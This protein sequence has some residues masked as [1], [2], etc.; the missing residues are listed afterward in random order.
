M[1]TRYDRFRMALLC[2]L[3]IPML[4]RSEPAPTTGV[5]QV[6][7]QVVSG[8]RVNTQPE[9]TAGLDFGSLD[10]GRQP[11]LFGVALTARALSNGSAIRLR[12]TGVPSINVSVGLGLDPEGDQRRLSAGVHKVPYQL[13]ADGSFSQPFVGSMPRSLTVAP[14]GREAELEL[15][16]FGRISPIPGGYP[17]GQYSDQVGITVSW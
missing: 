4:A 3:S 13:Y 8:C 16:I 11:S 2:A 7:A 17:A 9:L 6:T 14:D 1:A 10:F 5:I 12:C 15:G